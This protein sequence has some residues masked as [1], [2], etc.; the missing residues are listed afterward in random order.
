M[1]IEKN[2][3]CPDSKVT[4]RTAVRTVRK[5]GI[6]FGTWTL[7]LGPHRKKRLFRSEIEYLKGPAPFPV[8]SERLRSG[9]EHR[10]YYMVQK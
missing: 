8:R 3:F 7:D 4:A 2:Y 1:E 9:T 5:K 10:K 6:P